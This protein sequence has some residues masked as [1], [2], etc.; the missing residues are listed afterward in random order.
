V[1]GKFACLKFAEN[2]AEIPIKPEFIRK[3]PK[4]ILNWYM[5][6]FMPYAVREIEIC[7]RQGYEILL[8]T[9]AKENAGLLEK[10][11]EKVEAACIELGVKAMLAESGIYVSGNFFVPEGRL[12]KA[13]FLKQIIDK[14]LKTS[15][16]KAESAELIIIAGDENYTKAIIEFLYR[17]FNYVGVI[18]EGEDQGDYEEI[19]AEIFDD[20][21]LVLNFGR[22]GSY[23]L[24][25]ADIIV[26][27]SEATKGYESFYKKGACYIELAGEKEKLKNL[28]AKREG[29]TA[30]DKFNVEYMGERLGLIQYEML[31]FLEQPDFMRCFQGKNIRRSFPLAAESLEKYSVKVRNLN[32]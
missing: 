14:Y 25:D 11:M 15:A 20:C 26:N 22:R 28:L 27:L 9:L 12:V 16:I 10:I 8:P 13:F 2:M 7:S 21:G 18:L 5:S 32:I 1:E 30:V 6:K 24:K 31:V 3:A 4:K 23:L 19:S 29:I 17:S